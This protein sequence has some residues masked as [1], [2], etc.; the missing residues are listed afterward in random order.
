MKFDSRRE[1]PDILNELG[2]LGVG[3]EAGVQRAINGSHIRGV[4]KGKCY[5]GVDPWAPYD[6]VRDT[7]EQHSMYMADAV[8][9]LGGTGK[10]FQLLRMKSLD[11]A[12]FFSHFGQP[13]FDWVYLDDD[14][15]YEP[16]KQGIEQWWPLIKSGG[17]LAGHDYVPDGW[18]ANGDPVTSYPSA[19]AAGVHCGPFE[20]IK[21]VQE[22]FGPGGKLETE[23]FLTS[24]DTDDGWRSWLVKKP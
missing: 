11:A 16:V 12:R 4:W 13:L 3:V 9:H 14:H 6:G 22:M 2:L 1:F 19:E 20:V 10:P 5:V 15:F 21:A 18:H 23:I 8:K 24:P 17:I 7:Q